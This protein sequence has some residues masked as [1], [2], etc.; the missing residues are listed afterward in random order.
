MPGRYSTIQE[1]A[2]DGDTLIPKPVSSV[3]KNV[4]CFVICGR[5]S[6][7]L[8]PSLIF[9]IVSLQVATTRETVAYRRTRLAKKVLGMIDYFYVWQ[10]A[11]IA[12]N[13]SFQFWVLQVVGSNPAAPT[14]KYLILSRLIIARPGRQIQNK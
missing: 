4:V 11:D 14:N 12:R 6:N 7:D 3:S 5:L 8:F 13:S 2:P 10:S 9:A 1:R